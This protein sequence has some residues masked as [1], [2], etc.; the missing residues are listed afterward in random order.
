MNC[1]EIMTP[2]YLRSKL[3]QVLHQSPEVLRVYV[4]T[5]HGTVNRSNPLDWRNI[6]LDATEF[7]TQE[8]SFKIY[9]YIA[10]CT[11]IM[12]TIHKKIQTVLCSFC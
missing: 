9:T 3:L 4:C 12:Q 11:H 5:Y 2:S 7:L 1:C 6:V 8:M 10:F